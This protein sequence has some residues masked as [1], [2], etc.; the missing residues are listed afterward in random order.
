[1]IITPNE[2]ALV[3]D[4]SVAVKINGEKA[5]KTL[6]FRVGVK[7]RSLGWIGIGIIVFVIAG[8]LALFRKLGRR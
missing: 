4:Y 1:M 7:A 8:L 5:S 2:D 6:E 3:G